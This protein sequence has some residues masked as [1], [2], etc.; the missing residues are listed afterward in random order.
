MML[1]RCVSGVLSFTIMGRHKGKI[2][3]GWY[4]KECLEEFA[5]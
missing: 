4:A 3:D 2:L 5:G 1:A